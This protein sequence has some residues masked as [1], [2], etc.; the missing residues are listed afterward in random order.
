M[1]HS[2]FFHYSLTHNNRIR[3]I[4]NFITLSFTLKSLFLFFIKK[5]MKMFP[6]KKDS[7]SF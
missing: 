1:F 4:S 6:F 7:V 3:N 5:F 2:K